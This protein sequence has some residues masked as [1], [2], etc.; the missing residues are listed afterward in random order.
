MNAIVTDKKTKVKL[1]VE[2]KIYSTTHGFIN[3]SGWD[4]VSKVI[5]S[6]CVVAKVLKLVKP[7]PSNVNEE[8]YKRD[9]GYVK[10]FSLIT[11]NVLEVETVKKSK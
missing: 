9:I 7:I 11:H 5:P 8:Y 3:E 1:L 10:I 2:V 6:P 4:V